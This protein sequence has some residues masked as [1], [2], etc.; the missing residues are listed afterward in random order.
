[1]TNITTREEI[2]TAKKIIIDRVIRDSKNDVPYEEI[3]ERFSIG[4]MKTY[5]AMGL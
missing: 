2:E 5:K 1:M 4:I 3:V